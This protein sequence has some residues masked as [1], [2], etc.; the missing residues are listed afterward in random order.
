MAW[1]TLLE[2]LISG[3]QLQLWPGYD[4]PGP[5]AAFFGATLRRTSMES[6]KGSSKKGSTL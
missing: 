4:Y 6:G 2:G 5:P 3:L 1:P